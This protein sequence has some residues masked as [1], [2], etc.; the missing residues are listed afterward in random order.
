[1]STPL[2]DAIDFLQYE[3]LNFRLHQLSTDPSSPVSGQE[4]W[5]TADLHFRVHNGSG[6]QVVPFVTSA[7]P[8]ADTVGG[9][10]A[11]GTSLD[12]ARADHVHAQP[13]LATTGASGYMSAADKTALTNA[14]PSPTASTLVQRDAAARFQAADPVAAQDVATLAYVQAMTTGMAPKA[15]CRAKST[16]NVVISNPGTAVFDGVTLIAGQ[17]LLLGSQAAPAENGIY[18]FNGSGV[19][20]SRASDEDTWAEVVGAYTVI[21]EGTVNA[22]TGW[23]CTSDIGGTLGTTAITWVPFGNGTA[24]TASNDPAITG[25]GVYDNTT[26]TQFRFRAIKLGSSKVTVTLSGKDILIDV[27]EANILLP[28]LGGTLPITKGGTGAITVAG[29]KTALGFMSRFA[30]TV[31]DGVASSFNVNHALATT[32]VQVTVQELTGLKRQILG[33]TVAI[34]DANNIAVSFGRAPAVNA[35]R[36]VVIG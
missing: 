27:V 9:A 6:F 11:V 15:S 4:Y 13:G 8:S 17:R 25:T 16:G 10:G 20:L 28:N 12:A 22:D 19:A 30:A 1:M 2:G 5:N 14:T 29:A 31:G 7:T 26:G 23:L 24:F 21:S 32:D 18:I 3:G 35:Y 36:V 34:T 33:T